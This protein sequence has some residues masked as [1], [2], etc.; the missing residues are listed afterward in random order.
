MLRL[1]LLFCITS[2]SLKRDESEHLNPNN[3]SFEEL[4]AIPILNESDVLTILIMRDLGPYRGID[5][6]AERTKLDSSKIEY[7]KDIFFF[8]ERNDTFFKSGKIQ[9]EKYRKKTSVFLTLSTLT[10][11]FSTSAVQ[12]TPFYISYDFITVGKFSLSI[13]QNS[14]KGSPSLNGTDY[15]IYISKPFNFAIG[16]ERLYIGSEL[17]YNAFTPF[18]KVFAHKGENPKLL[19]GMTLRHRPVRASLTLLP[20][21]NEFAVDFLFSTK[22]SHYR[23]QWEVENGTINATYNLTRRLSSTNS[24]CI[25]YSG[26][27]KKYVNLDL[28]QR[29][30]NETI[31]IVKSSFTESSL[32]IRSGKLESKNLSIEYG[33]LRYEY[34]AV[35]FSLWNSKIQF[36]YYPTRQWLDICSS[37]T[38]NIREKEIKIEIGRTHDEKYRVSIGINLYAHR[39]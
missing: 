15:L 11:K 23:M 19:A 25:N 36:S 6:F 35:K 32:I 2:I 5:D 28:L 37:A 24:L 8:K 26:S 22:N 16:K 3:A 10:L 9:L 39:R 31:L 13:P 14:L 33:N 34:V 17:S 20:M 27:S 30:G 1:I 38:F 21:E 12:T 7:L 4:I 18:L 29:L